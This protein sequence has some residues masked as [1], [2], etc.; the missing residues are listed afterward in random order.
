MNRIRHATIHRS[1]LLDWLVIANASRARIF[2]RDE[3]NSALREI[4]DKVHPEA[5]EKKGA[6][7]R[8]RP[9][10]VHKGVM[11]TAFE[12]HTTPRER[13]RT[14]FAHELAQVLEQAAVARRMRG[15]VLL[16]SN[17]FLGALKAELGPTA[18][19]FLRG[20]FPVDLTSL[21]GSELE[22]HVTKVL[23][24]ETGSAVSPP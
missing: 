7:D 2:E 15:L 13:E 16:A 1:V 8:D 4:T 3:D 24:A 5:R 10:R 23:R 11:S 21:Q 9:G 14:E 17:P 18:R 22:H 6:L 12:P 20:Q 19:T